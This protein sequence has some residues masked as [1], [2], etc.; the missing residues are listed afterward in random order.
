MPQPKHVPSKLDLLHKGIYPGIAIVL[1]LFSV[2]FA[3]FTYWNSNDKQRQIDRLQA[4]MQLV[5]AQQQE[6]DR[7]AGEDAHKLRVEICK[8]E[9]SPVYNFSN[10]ED[11]RKAAPFIRTS[12]WHVRYVLEQKD[13]EQHGEDRTRELWDKA[14]KQ[15]EKEVK[16]G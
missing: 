8:L 12:Y 6:Q 11:E 14:Q 1:M 5:Q 4:Q 3:V 16:K 9:L 7:R 2:G 15:A 10:G 13:M